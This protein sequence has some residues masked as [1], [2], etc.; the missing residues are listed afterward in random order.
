MFCQT[1]LKLKAFWFLFWQWN[2]KYNPEI[3]KTKFFVSDGNSSE[4]C[5]SYS[6]HSISPHVASRNIALL[7][8]PPRQTG[9]APRWVQFYRRTNDDKKK[10][11]NKILKDWQIG[12][13]NE[14]ANQGCG[15]SRRTG[16][17]DHI[18]RHHMKNLINDMTLWV[19]EINKTMRQNASDAPKRNKKGAAKDGHEDGDLK[20]WRLHQMDILFLY[21]YLGDNCDGSKEWES[22][23]MNT[24]SCIIV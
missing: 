5:L 21:L 12:N 24:E 20:G 7:L 13:P 11:S 16:D 4:T 18:K 10:L 23:T 8:E 22:V 17:R 1:R 3:M 14:C 6:C 2:L 19:K 15:F 9:A